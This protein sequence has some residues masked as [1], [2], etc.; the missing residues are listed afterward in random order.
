MMIAADSQTDRAVFAVCD[1]RIGNR[2]IIQID[3]IIQCAYN[4]MND[5]GKLFLVVYINI[6]QRQTGQIADDKISRLTFIN[7]HALS[8]DFHNAAFFQL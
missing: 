6:P 3:Y 8:V 5:M 7:Y 2:I 4:N 1:F